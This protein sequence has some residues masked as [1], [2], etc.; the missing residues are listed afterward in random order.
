MTQLRS[1]IRVAKFSITLIKHSSCLIMVKNKTTKIEDSVLD[2][3]TEVENE[4]R[5]K[6]S[7]Q[8]LEIMQEITNLKPKLWSGGI[9]GFGDYHYKYD[10]GHEG[11]FFRAGFSPRKKALTL[12]IMS[13][14]SR[15][16]E[17]LEKLGKH[18]IGKSC[19]YINN[20]KDVDLN[21]LKQMITLSFEWMNKKYPE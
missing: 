19:L 2:F 18:K 8:V 11:D 21:V 12:Y 15:Y 3:L 5:R 6:D 4:I 10:S 16:D 7:F 14:F 1:K 13:G 9:I 20:L 17:L